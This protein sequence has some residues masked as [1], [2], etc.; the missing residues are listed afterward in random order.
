MYLVVT[1]DANLE[2]RKNI[3]SIVKPHLHWI[4]ESV[5]SGELT[6]TEAEDLFRKL[7]GKI[8]N[9]KISFWLFDR[10]PEIRQIGTQVD[11]ESIFL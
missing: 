2:E 8:K 11:K 3:R 10:P 1:Y 5:Y 6:R 9:A 7:R 4:Q